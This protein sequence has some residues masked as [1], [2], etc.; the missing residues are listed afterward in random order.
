MKLSI[1]EGL[2][3]DAE[4][5]GTTEL[6]AKFKVT[7]DGQLSLISLDGVPVEEDVEEEEE[8]EMS[9]EG[10]MSEE[11]LGLLLAAIDSEGGD[12]PPP[13]SSDEFIA[14]KSR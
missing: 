1:P 3:I 14:S 6:L 2:Q 10:E 9:E 12:L 7:E 11:E 4:A 8:V 13:P 5:G